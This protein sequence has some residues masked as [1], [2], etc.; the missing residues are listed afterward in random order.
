MPSSDEL[1]PPITSTSQPS[2]R[3]VFDWFK[4]E[5]NSIPDDD[6]PL[7]SPKVI[8]RAAV[9]NRFP[10]FQSP[11]ACKEMN[12]EGRSTKGMKGVKQ[13]SSLPYRTF[14]E[15]LEET[16]PPL[17]GRKFNQ[18]RCYLSTS[19][20]TVLSV[21]PPPPSPSEMETDPAG[22]VRKVRRGEPF[23]TTYGTRLL[24]LWRT[25]F[26]NALLALHFNYTDFF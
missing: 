16:K 9:E 2:A 25:L 15:S 10:P 24:L 8:C 23:S 21:E 13:S 3:W 5:I 12:R 4:F 17:R 14:P 7:I 1:P 11:A 6:T 18:I 26:R 19:W 22:N 20:R